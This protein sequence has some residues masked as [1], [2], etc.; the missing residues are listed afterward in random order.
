MA[1]RIVL[2]DDHTVVREGLR[3]LLESEGDLNVVGEAA[4]GITTV[5]LV[6]ELSPDI[7]VMDVSMPD[8]NGV[9]ATRQILSQVPTVRV[10]GL[11]VHE[12]RKIVTEMLRAGASA[13]LLKSCAARELRRAIR[14][15]IAGHAYLS[16]GVANDV[17][18]DFLQNDGASQQKSAFQTLTPRE[19][20]VLQ[21]LA[22]GSAPK[23]IAD[24]LH[25]SVKTVQTH[26]QHI[27]EKVGTHN[28]A[29]LTKYAIREGLTTLDQWS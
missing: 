16:P 20:E 5:E 8:L 13:Y 14:E 24:R 2:A 23:Q 15:V 10:L 26:R 17:I 9:E 4:D 22:E 7:V 1:I 6:C 12:D 19:R 11:S 18:Q 28:L 3:T 21:L 25:I 27:M 29:N